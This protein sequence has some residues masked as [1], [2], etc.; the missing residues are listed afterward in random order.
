MQETIQQWLLYI[1]DKSEHYWVGGI[2][3][4]LAIIGVRFI[5][6]QAIQHFFKSKQAADLLNSVINWLFILILFVF[7][8]TYFGSEPWLFKTLFT[9][10]GTDISI[11][12]ILTLA[13]AVYLA[14][15]TTEFL[16]RFIFPIFY[17][18]YDVE[19]GNQATINSIFSLIVFV[20]VVYF[21]L[22]Q[23]GFNMTSLTIF[24]GVLGVGIGFGIRN[25]MNNFI[26]GII[27]LF[28]RPIQVGDL[29]VINNTVA[30]VEQ[31]KLRATIVT[32]RRNE[33]LIIPN[34]HFLEEKFVNRSYTNRDLRIQIDLGID[35]TSD[36]V[37]A[38]QLLIKAVKNVQK[39]WPDILDTPA[40][41]IFFE[42]FGESSLDFSLWVWISSQRDEREFRIA[43]DLR[44]EI[45]ELFTANGIEFAFPRHDVQ[46][47]NMDQQQE[48]G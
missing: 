23:L 41:R 37:L 20:S 43:S 15:K 10:D 22:V 30:T 2:I 13:F 47:L 7:A 29:I 45:Y 42:D 36:I 3:G 28:E 35:Y 18:R 26:S 33:R 32:T 44:S 40:P 46:I 25:I 8:L 16:R 6:T 1:E 27:L 38:R 17:Q 34:S 31:I 11:F 4:A 14:K 5:L 24:T 9:I 48:E 12:F 21:V 19:K 39:N